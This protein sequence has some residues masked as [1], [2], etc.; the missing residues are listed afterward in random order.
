MADLRRLLKAPDLAGPASA[1]GTPAVC[2]DGYE[3]EI[4]S[5]SVMTSVQDCATSH[6]ATLDRILA[7]VAAVLDR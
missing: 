3:Y 7:I 4:V 1:T 2:N 5:P 6:G